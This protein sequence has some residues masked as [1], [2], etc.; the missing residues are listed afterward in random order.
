MLLQAQRAH[1]EEALARLLNIV[2]VISFGALYG[3]VAAWALVAT[4]TP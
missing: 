2:L 4:V 1:R 3:A